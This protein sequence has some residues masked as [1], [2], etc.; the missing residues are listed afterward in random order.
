MSATR[1]A[2]R[3]LPGY[4]SRRLALV[5]ERP[6]AGV[7][8]DVLFCIADHYEPDHHCSDPARQTARVSRWAETYPRLAEGLRDADGRP[9][10]YSFF[11]PAEIYSP[12]LVTPLAELCHEGLGE[13]DVHLHHGNDTSANLRETLTRFTETLAADHGLL[14]RSPDGRLAYGF[15]HGDWALDNSH[16]DDAVCGVN[17]EITVLRETG[18][19]AD[20]TMP[21]VFYPSQS[22]V[23]NRIY[24]AVDDPQRPGSHLDGAIAQAGTPA[25]ADALLMIPGPLALNWAQRIKGVLPRIE[26]GAIDYRTPPTL[27]RFRRWVDAGVTVAG[28]PEWV[29]VKVHTHG[30]PEPNADVMLGGPYRTMLAEALAHYNDGVTTRL[31]FVTA[32]EMANIAWAAIDGKAGNAGAYRDYRLRPVSPPRTAPDPTLPA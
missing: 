9:P 12:H 19:Y 23:V 11:F 29:F 16:H 15:I 6:A 17:D 22:R 26:S 3:W 20:F 7:T 31:H 2:E 4:V 25:P 32:R 14:S 10:R 1:N 24:H 21:S 8:R 5:G 18:C 30:A 28:R 13:F 27:A